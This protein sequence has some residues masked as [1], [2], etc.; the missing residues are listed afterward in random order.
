MVPNSRAHTPPLAGEVTGQKDLSL[1]AFS[2][3]T[4]GVS[5]YTNYYEKNSLRMI[6]WNFGGILHSRVST[7]P[8]N[9]NFLKE[10][11]VK[12]VTFTKILGSAKT[13]PVQFKWGF[14]HFFHS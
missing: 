2:F 3:L 5:K 4:A 11:R 1:C 9:Q 8:R 10:L 14:G 13:D 6:F 7:S 12:F